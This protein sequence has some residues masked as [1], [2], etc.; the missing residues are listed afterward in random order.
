GFAGFLILT[1]TD[2]ISHNAIIYPDIP[3]AKEPPPNLENK[4][5][6]IIDVAYKKNILE[7]IFKKANFVLFIDHHVTIRNDVLQLIT[8]FE[9]IHKVVYDSS[10]S[11][12]TLT[13]D[14]FYPNKK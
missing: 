11:G 9:N 4:N 5:V 3:S 10:K 8:I 13:W 1:T 7:Q 14:Y 12:A 2:K 6:I